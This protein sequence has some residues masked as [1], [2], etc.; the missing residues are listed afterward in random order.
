MKK[1]ILFIS[2]FIFFLG[3]FIGLGLDSYADTNNFPTAYVDFQRMVGGEYKSFNYRCLT[4]HCCVYL[5]NNTYFFATESYILNLDTSE[6]ASNTIFFTY[7]GEPQSDR[8]YGS[9]Y[10]GTTQYVNSL[11]GSV[12]FDSLAAARAYLEQGDESGI[13]SGGSL[14]SPSID[15]GSSGSPLSPGSTPD[16]YNIPAPQFNISYDTDGNVVHSITFTNFEYDSR[17]QNGKYGLVLSASWATFDNFTLSHTGSL[18]DTTYTVNYG[19]AILDEPVFEIFSVPTKENEIN[20]C[21]QSL[22]F[23]Q[24][25]V[26]LSNFGH[27]ISNNPVADRT[28]NVP[29]SE[30]NDILENQF[31][32]FLSNASCP[33]NYIVFSCFYYKP[34]GDGTFS[35]GPTTTGSFYPP[36]QGAIYS[37]GRLNG[38]EG[39]MSPGSGG[40]AGGNGGNWNGNWG[41]G[42]T[43]INLDYGSNVDPSQLV[44]NMNSLLGFIGNVPNFVAQ[45]FSFLP[46]W[47]IVFI[48]VSIGLMVAIGVVKLFLG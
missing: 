3:C 12:V 28:V 44:N 21:P 45:L 24:N 10:L 41:D 29:A 14:I 25:A 22:N 35:F 33:Y 8:Y 23:N 4:Q 20:Y 37:A 9:V 1:L 15:W 38:Q 48:A 2:S 6:T 46:E 39:N 27:M 11:S 36:N 31:K 40:G 5:D 19:S 42:N 43:N 30:P 26:S 47:L 17:I 32:D 16:T 18:F 13:V 7:D 34:N